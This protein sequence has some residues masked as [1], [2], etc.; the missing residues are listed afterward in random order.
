LAI[1][2]LRA[3]HHLL[4]AVELFSPLILQTEDNQPQQGFQQANK[5]QL[6]VFIFGFGFSRDSYRPMFDYN[7]SLSLLRQK[8][9]L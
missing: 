7:V 9:Y 6:F 5:Y 8:S 4:F 3:F 1:V 2:S